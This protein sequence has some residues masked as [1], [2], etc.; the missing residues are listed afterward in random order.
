MTVPKSGSV[1]EKR[2]DELLRDIF[3]SGEVADAAGQ[4]YKLHSGI[5]REAG[6]RIASVIRERGY[7]RTLEIGCAYGLSSLYISKGLS[8]A[9]HPS[10]TI[11]DAFQSGDW[12][13]V[14]LANLARAGV[15][16][17]HLI[18]KPSEIALPQMVADGCEFDFIFI[19]GWHTFDHTLVDFFYSNRLLRVGGVVAIDDFWLAP[20]NRAV[21][22]AAK[23][24]H[25]RVLRAAEASPPAL[26]RRVLD[27]TARIVR[28][29]VPQGMRREVFNDTFLHSNAMLG[30]DMPVIFLEKTAIDARPWDWYSSF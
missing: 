8:Q 2:V 13:G 7:S 9:T 17:H 19:D 24:P 22:Y 15:T 11:I 25:Y 1:D 5:S 14:G 29:V 30:L 26:R 27:L 28:T 4:K 23:Y 20:V 12:H 16:I 18:E 21:R 3:S 6:E 10:H